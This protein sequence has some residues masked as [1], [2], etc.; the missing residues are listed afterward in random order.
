MQGLH[1]LHTVER[2]EFVDLFKEILPYRHLM[3]RRTLGRMLDDEYSSMK[4][5]LTEKFSTLSHVCTTTDAWSANNRS[6]LGVTIH[7]I[8]EK[9]LSICSGALACRRIVGSHTHDVL[10]EMLDNVHRDFKIKDK[11]TITT[12]DNGANFV[13][14]FSV[15]AEVQIESLREEENE[16]GEE[17]DTVFI[18]LTDILNEGD[19]DEEVSLPP[20]QRCACHTLNLVATKDIETAVSKSDQLQ[21]GVKS[22][23]RQ[24]SSHLE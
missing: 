1:P 14:S 9:S 4:R 6:F 7:W 22:N 23:D 5:T 3:S 11:V 17:D 20:H 21:K 16:E 15:F 8:D 12:T 24:M 10:A 2:P 13:K 19:V 18:S